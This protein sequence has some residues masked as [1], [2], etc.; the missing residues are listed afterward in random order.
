MSKTGHGFSDAVDKLDATS[1][2][3]EEFGVGGARPPVAPVDLLS[4]VSD[5]LSE[6]R[7]IAD[8]NGWR[9]L[10]GLLALAHAEAGIRRDD[11]VAR[12]QG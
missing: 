12:H 10:S 9:T 3:T 1:A 7:E 11:L 5:M 8:E 2:D 4:Y 6:L